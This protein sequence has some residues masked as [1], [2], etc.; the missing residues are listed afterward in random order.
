MPACTCAR[1]RECA[2]VRDGIVPPALTVNAYGQPLCTRAV[3]QARRSTHA[4]VRTCEEY[5]YSLSVIGPR[6]HAYVRDGNTCVVA[7]IVLVGSRVWVRRVYTCCVHVRGCVH[8]RGCLCVFSV[9]RA[10]SPIRQ[11]NRFQGSDQGI[12]IESRSEVPC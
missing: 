7:L 6:A 9:G 11:G 10:Q 4:R 12:C 8:K 2:C 3:T 5:M 1:V